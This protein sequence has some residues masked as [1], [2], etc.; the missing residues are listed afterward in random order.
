MKKVLSILLVTAIMMIALIGCGSMEENAYILK[1]V[2][3]NGSPIKGVSM[4]VCSTTQ[5]MLFETDDNGEAVCKDLPE[6]AYEVHI[7]SC[8]DGYSY[9]KEEVYTTS[10]TFETHT[11]TLSSN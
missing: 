7:I 6:M 9:D 5:C 4:Q 8:P 2:D 10:E 1:C 11:F 3:A